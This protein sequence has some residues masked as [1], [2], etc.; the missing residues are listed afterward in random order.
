MKLKSKILLFLAA[1]FLLFSMIVW[2]YSMLLS[3]RT[4]EEW[5]KIYV[6]SQINFDKSRALLPIMREITVIKQMSREHAL[7]QMALNDENATLREK[8]LEVLERYRLKFQDKSYFAAFL[9]SQNYYYNNSTNDYAQNRL[10]YKLSKEN[11]EHRWFYDAIL[12]GDEYQININ[13]DTMLGVTKVWIN[14]LL[15]DNNNQTIGIIG[16]GF[17]LKKFLKESVDLKQEGIYNV[18]IN[19]SMSIQLERDSELID[20]SSLSV[21]YEKHKTLS[22]IIKNDEEIQKIKEEMLKLEHLDK[23]NSISTLWIEYKG[24]KQLLSMIYLKEL[25]WYGITIINAKKLILL[26]NFSVFLVFCIAFLIA[27][28]VISIIYN[29]LLLNPITRLKKI[30]REVEHGKYEQH[31]PII[32][33]GEI[34]ELSKQFKSMLEFVIRNNSEL[35]SKIEERTAILKESQ[36]E[37]SSILENVDAFIHIKD[38]NCK[39]TYANKN[40]IHFLGLPLDEILTKDDTAFFDENTANMIRKNDLHV[41]EKGIKVEVEE[42]ITNPLNNETKVFL[43]IRTPLFRKDGSVYAICTTSSDITQRKLAEKKIHDLASYDTL[44]QLPNRRLLMERLEQAMTL[45]YRNK[46]YGAVMFLDL[47]NFKPL[48][49][50]YGHD[51]GD[52]LLVEVAARIS[53]CLRD[54]D[55]VSRYGGDEFVVLLCELSLEKDEA[56]KSARV[57]A[58]KIRVSLEKPFILNVL[59]ENEEK[60]IEHKITASIGVT[61][62]MDNDVTIENVLKSADIAMY[63]AKESGR[64]TIHFSS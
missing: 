60:R 25:G 18:F 46:F 27:L 23:E 38:V 58:E 35:E 30:M 29:R 52:N 42:T 63:K 3:E 59:S 26:N 22:L 43:S 21:P 7:I 64:N 5:G 11:K 13:R 56:S 62:F 34:A 45:S 6:K 16:T 41:I 48:N 36:Q 32:G 31:I 40:V 20:Y 15:K 14:L 8:G 1:I 50:T 33:S 51:R 4:N 55:T 47:D 10:A 37:I 53:S 57:V 44:T 28:V 54:I 24:K 9:K 19:K 12:L 39:Y 49:D 2:L 17:D 61:L